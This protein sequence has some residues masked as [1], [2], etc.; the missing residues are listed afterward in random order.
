[1][2]RR[3]FR[4]VIGNILENISLNTNLDL[5]GKDAI[6]F[7]KRGCSEKSLRDGWREQFLSAFQSLATTEVFDLENVLV[8]IFDSIVSKLINARTNVFVK[9][10]KDKN[11]SR[12]F[13]STSGTHS[14]LREKLKQS[15][16]LIGRSPF[17]VAEDV[18][19]HLFDCMVTLKLNHCARKLSPESDNLADFELRREPRNEADSNA[20]FLYD[21][22]ISSEGSADSKIAYVDIAD[23]TTLHLIMDTMVLDYTSK[24]SDR[25][26]GALC[27]VVFIA[28]SKDAANQQFK[29]RCKI[30]MYGKRNRDY[31]A[32]SD[33]MQMASKDALCKFKFFDL[34][35]EKFFG[36]YIDLAAPAVKK[37]RQPKQKLE[38][39][40]K[41]I[42]QV[43]R[44]AD[45][46]IPIPTPTPTFSDHIRTASSSSTINAAAA[47]PEG[48]VRLVI[49]NV[50]LVGADLN[51]LKPAR[52]RKRSDSAQ[53]IIAP[54]S[55]L[56]SSYDLK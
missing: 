41:Q 3:E 4:S 29:V 26:R 55:L 8:P 40:S 38:F 42:P 13:T 5:R 28:H 39:F 27:K 7:V 51:Q 12:F 22:A 16:S 33:Y 36:N 31:T 15:K 17:P 24:A 45:V 50:A 54:P 14:E 23:A 49:G 6:E 10:F 43:F 46:P 44:A 11:F 30:S 20:I 18:T 9:D 19:D 35:K 1:M 25:K 37:L 52:K 47:A 56:I 32:L 53:G 2:P 48:A 34:K 21:S